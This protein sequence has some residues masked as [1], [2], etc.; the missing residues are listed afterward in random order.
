MIL[1]QACTVWN[2]ARVYEN[3]FSVRRVRNASSA[4]ALRIES[5]LPG[6][7]LVA[8]VVVGRESFLPSGALFSFICYKLFGRTYVYA[9]L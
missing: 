2:G 9:K 8:V 7:L 4:A 1:F 3:M 6:L 5:R